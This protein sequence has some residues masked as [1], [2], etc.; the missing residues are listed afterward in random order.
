MVDIPRDKPVFDYTDTELK[1]IGYDLMNEMD[2]IQKNLQIIRNEIDRRKHK[3]VAE[4]SQDV[5]QNE[6]LK[7]RITN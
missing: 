7:G 6:A 1:S 4:M 5:L 3:V 2:L